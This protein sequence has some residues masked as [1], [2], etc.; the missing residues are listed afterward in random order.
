MVFVFV[1]LI[2]NLLFWLARGT[3]RQ[4]IVS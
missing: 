2:G 1:G 4:E 3:I